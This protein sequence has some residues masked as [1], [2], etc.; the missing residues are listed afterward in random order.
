MV[1]E[2][3]CAILQDIFELDE[4][5]LTRDTSFSDTLNADIPD[6]IELS[7]ILE[8]EFEITISESELEDIETVGDLETLI[9][10][11]SEF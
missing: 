1:Y 4:G 3:L 9:E 5:L 6:L 2:K 11:K 10:E 7:M 8:E